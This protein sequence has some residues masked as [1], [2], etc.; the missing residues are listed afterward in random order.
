M[1]QKLQLGDFG[2]ARNQ[3]DDLENPS[4]NS[5]VGT[6]GYVA[7]EYAEC[8]KASTKTDVYSFGVV[9][10]QLITGLR[11]TDKSLGAKSLVGWV[12]TALCSF[13]LGRVNFLRF[14]QIIDIVTGQTTPERE[15]LPRFN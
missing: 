6:L 15:E 10:L 3:Y 13:V 12:K 11:T 8:G 7:P 4:E 1:N 2:L 14:S 5:V 9:L